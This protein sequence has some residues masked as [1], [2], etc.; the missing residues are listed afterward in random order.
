MPPRDAAPSSTRSALGGERAP[1]PRA[2][3][4]MEDA[5]VDAVVAID[6]ASD[7][8]ARWDAASVREEL[9]RAWARLWV[10]RAADGRARPQE[11][12]AVAAFLVTWLVADEL[13]VLNI[14]THPAQRRRGHARALL[15]H[16]LAFARANGVRLVLLEVR[17]GNAGAIA[18]YR[19]TG[20]AAIGLRSRYYPDDEDAVEMLLRIDPAT[21]AI[22]QAP[23]EVT[24]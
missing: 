2:I 1:L 11:A 17:R 8:S 13:H 18:L 10:S 14:A 21:G 23:D 4:P 24:L 9:G 5:D 15:D 3:G 6:R 20:F 19:R 16:A 12:G 7:Q 22:V